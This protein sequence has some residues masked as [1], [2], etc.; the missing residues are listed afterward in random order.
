MHICKLRCE[1][2]HNFRLASRRFVML[3]VLIVR[4]KWKGLLV[5]VGGLLQI[6][7]IVTAVIIG[8]YN[9]DV[10]EIEDIDKG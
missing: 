7:L 4:F 8:V 10:L 9:T 1:E 3:C 5:G 6:S 2:K